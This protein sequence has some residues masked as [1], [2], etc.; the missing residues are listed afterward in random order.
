MSWRYTYG[1][2]DGRFDSEEARRRA[3]ARWSDP[4]AAERWRQAIRASVQ[5]P[6]RRRQLSEQAKRRW[7]DPEWRART[8][9]RLIEANRDPARRA[10]LR[11]HWKSTPRVRRPRGPFVIDGVPVRCSCCG[12]QFTKARP[13]ELDHRIP[14]A[15]GGSDTSANANWLCSLCHAYKS[16]SERKLLLHLRPA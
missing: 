15:F 3:I 14:M 11:E 4:E 10:K 2:A 7:A 6:E 5:G 1:V 16:V 8:T 9:A 12:R 13:P